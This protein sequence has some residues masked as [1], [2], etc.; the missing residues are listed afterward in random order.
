MPDLDSRKTPRWGTENRDGK[1]MAILST[2]LAY[3][4]ESI[5]HSVWVDLGCGSGGIVENLA[6]HVE[7]II[8]VDPE[9]WSDW[10][11]RESANPNLSFIIAR[12]DE[13]ELPLPPNTADVVICNQVY[14]HVSSPEKLLENIYAI[15]KPGGVCYFAGPNLLWPLEPHLFWPFIHWLPRRFAQQ[16]MVLLGSKQADFFDAYSTHYWKLMSWMKASGFE[17]SDGIKVRLRF[18]LE[19]AKKMRLAKNLSKIPRPI[20]ALLHPFSPGFVFI[21]R[22]P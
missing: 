20:Y 6:P 10:S 7:R 1:A 9:P 18:A 14:E 11:A 12:C 17:I 22:K 21:L 19:H 16:T 4:D 3:T 8:G 2:L 13:S 15:L 5:L